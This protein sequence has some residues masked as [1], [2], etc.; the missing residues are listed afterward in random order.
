MMT[1]WAPSCYLACSLEVKSTTSPSAYLGAVQSLIAGR[2]GI[3]KSTQITHSFGAGFYL[4]FPVIPRE[5]D[6]CLAVGKLTYP[7][8]QF[9]GTKRFI[10]STES[11][12]G[13]RNPTLGIAYIVVGSICL[14]LGILFLILHY[15]LPRSSECWEHRGGKIMKWWREIILVIVWVVFA[16][17]DVIHATHSVLGWQLT[18]INGVHAV[19]SYDT[20]L[21]DC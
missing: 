11:W 4:T 9:G 19:S 18:D 14:V 21:N 8:T 5:R 17:Q 13:G 10:L 7:V 20:C 3:H 12:L 2:H 16:F 15:R 1:Q 6:P